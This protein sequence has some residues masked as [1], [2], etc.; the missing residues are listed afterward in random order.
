MI[1]RLADVNLALNKAA[2]QISTDIGPASYAVDGD[3]TT[4]SCTLDNAGNPWWSVDLG[5]SYYIDRVAITFP[6][7]GS[8][9]GIDLRNYD[10]FYFV[11]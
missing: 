8:I 5:Q 11:Q 6:N 4:A 1:V 7:F 3:V 10:R 9:D 2:S